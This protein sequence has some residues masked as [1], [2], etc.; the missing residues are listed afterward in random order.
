MKRR[1]ERIWIAVAEWQARLESRLNSGDETGGR[2]AALAIVE[3]CNCGAIDALY[4]TSAGWAAPFLSRPPS[5]RATTAAF[6]LL[7]LAELTLESPVVQAGLLR[8]DFNSI[9]P[10]ALTWGNLALCYYYENKN[11]SAKISSDRAIGKLTACGPPDRLVAVVMEETRSCA[12][13]EKLIS[14]V[15]SHAAILHRLSFDEDALPYA[16]LAV[17]LTSSLHDYVELAAA[18]RLTIA[19]QRRRK[20]PVD[21]LEMRTPVALLRSISSLNA[22][23]ITLAVVKSTAPV[24]RKGL[25]H[26]DLVVVRRLLDS[27]KL[28]AVAGGPAASDVLNVVVHETMKLDA[29]VEPRRP[30]SAFGVPRPVGLGNHTLIGMRATQGALR[31]MKALKTIRQPPIQDRRVMLN[32]KPSM[33]LGD[34]WLSEIGL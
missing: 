17:T 20:A 10:E 32:A 18:E 15:A 1:E 9:W 2:D 30:Q 6:K 22:A 28:Y 5:N 27:A 24:K 3:K 31:S 33:L 29:A 19:E 11:R 12:I 7:K 14:V 34:T 13:A 4:G 21:L 16:Q 23:L 8:N 25:S 26:G